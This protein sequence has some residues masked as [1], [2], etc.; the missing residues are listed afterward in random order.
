MNSYYNT[1]RRGLLTEI[2]AVTMSIALMVTSTLVLE[3]SFKA[4]LLAS[5]HMRRKTAISM[6]VIR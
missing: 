5:Q 2:A 3:T 1:K 4:V 6:K